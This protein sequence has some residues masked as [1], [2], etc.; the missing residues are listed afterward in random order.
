[1][2]R[3]FDAL[4]LGGKGSHSNGGGGV[5]LRALSFESLDSRIWSKQKMTIGTCRYE[6]NSYKVSLK[7]CILFRG[8][9]RPLILG[10]APQAGDSCC[11]CERQLTVDGNV[12]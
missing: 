11:A 8:Q 6:V 2:F 12:A 9:I 10:E 4:K 5:Y 7:V 1:M 3:F